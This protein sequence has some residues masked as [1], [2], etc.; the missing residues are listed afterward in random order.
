MSIDLPWP[1]RRFPG[2]R[3]RDR[4]FKATVALGVR[5]NPASGSTSWLVLSIAQGETTALKELVL[6]SQASIII[7][8]GLPVTLG[9]SAAEKVWAAVA[10]LGRAASLLAAV[11]D[12]FYVLG[13]APIFIRYLDTILELLETVQQN[14]E[15]P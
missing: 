5:D 11:D 4:E 15:G 3:L 8:A 14:S 6:D 9:V 7:E 1:L 2:S 10:E 13:E 12:S